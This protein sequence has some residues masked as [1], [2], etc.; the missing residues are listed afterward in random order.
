MR[1]HTRTHTHERAHTRAHTSAHTHVRTH[2]HARTHTHTLFADKM[3]SRIRHV[4]VAGPC[5]PGLK[6]YELME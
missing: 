5:E 3:I 6:I 2:T 4:Q 1:A